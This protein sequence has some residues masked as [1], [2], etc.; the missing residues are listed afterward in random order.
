MK[1]TKRYGLNDIEGM[2]PVN[3]EIFKEF[4]RRMEEVIIP[5]INDIVEKRRLAAAKGRNKQ[6]K[7]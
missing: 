1:S 4:K 3:P 7:C 5:E 2:K 6:L